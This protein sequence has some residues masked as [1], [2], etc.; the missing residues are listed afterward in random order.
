[1]ESTFQDLA[2]DLIKIN[3]NFECL[4]ECFYTV[5]DKIDELGIAIARLDE[6]ENKVAAFSQI[7]D[8]PSNVES[9]HDH[10][11]SSRLDKL[12]FSASEV[13]REKR[14]L[15]IVVTHPNINNESSSLTDHLT[16]FFTDTMLMTTREI[17]SNFKA[18]RG[19]QKHAVLITF[20]CRLFKTFLFS[21]K[22]KLRLNNS[23]QVDNL[24]INDNLTK[25]NYDILKRLKTE[26]KNRMLNNLPCVSSIFSFDG[27]VFVKRCNGCEKIYIRDIEGMNN[28]MKS[29]DEEGVNTLSK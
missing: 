9:S 13:E 19:G 17:D 22:K 23:P 6:L 18:V 8:Q 3:N 16:I 4:M 25:Y 21:A 28:L 5:L 15:Q 1:M 10:H 29:I 20:S 27:K 26:K 14:Q 24:F 7:S 11:H 2:N 12:E